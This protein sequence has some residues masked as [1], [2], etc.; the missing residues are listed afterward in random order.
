MALITCHECGAKISDEAKACPSCGAKQKKPTSKMALVI[1]GLV[2]FSI[3]YGIATTPEPPEKTATQRAEEAA[4]EIEFQKV[5]ARLK[6]LKSVMKNPNSF[7]LVSAQMTREGSL[8]VTYRATNSF[9]AVITG[10]YAITDQEASDKPEAW[11]RL[12]T[13]RDGKDYMHARFAL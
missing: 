5:V 13:G 4:N 1:S 8:C 12:C 3:I 6:A 11:N 7:E 10:M 2:L 9:N